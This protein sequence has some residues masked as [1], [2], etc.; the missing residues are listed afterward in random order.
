MVRKTIFWAHL[1]V[2]VIICVPVLLLTVTGAMLAF[3]NQ[4]REIG[5][6]S[7]YSII[8]ET[9]NLPISKL[10]NETQFD[11][12]PK[13]IVLYSNKTD[14]V[15]FTFG[16]GMFLF[17]DPY[18]GEILGDHM[19]A[20]TNFM[21]SIF[22]L[23]GS[24]IPMFSMETRV[25]G[26]SVVGAINLAALL[27]LVSGLYLWVPKIFQWRFIKRNL[28]FRKEVLKNSKKR[29]YNWHLVL[30]I[31]SS[32]PLVVILLTATIMEY[33][34]VIDVKDSI[35]DVI[36]GE[37]ISKKVIT[38][39]PDEYKNRGLVKQEIEKALVAVK[40]YA[41]NWNT[42]AIKLPLIDVLPTMFTI[43][44]GNGRQ[45]Q[46]RTEIKINQYTNEIIDIKPFS[47]KSKSAQNLFLR[48]LHTGEVF[49]W[50]S[51]VIA[52]LTTISCLVIIWCGLALAYR[53]LIK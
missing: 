4:I 38:L 8:P 21:N 20:S 52:F 35:T 27:L 13:S 48:F 15:R 19:I 24:L 7:N 45:P 12:Q 51:Q 6:S 23:H 31:W 53:R 17:V 28:F 46:K 1:S 40:E 49:G 43:D 36:I 16:H 39:N 47:R 42:I 29:D 34:W 11:K 41:P 22:L 10:I 32:I 5:Y 26:Q 50:W 3:D 33:D 9:Q 30:G 25:T 14:A 37:E 18:T 44:E 2:A